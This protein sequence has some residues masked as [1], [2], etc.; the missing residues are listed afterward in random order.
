MILLKWFHVNTMVEFKIGASLEVNCVLATKCR[1]TS[2]I[3]LVCSRKRKRLLLS[4]SQW[5][6]GP[7]N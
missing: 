5:S 3:I 1:V 6:R 7:A 4:L 2:D